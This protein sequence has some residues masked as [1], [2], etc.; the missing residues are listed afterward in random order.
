MRRLTPWEQK[1]LVLVS[2][3]LGFNQASLRVFPSRDPYTVAKEIGQAIGKA[4]L[5]GIIQKRRAV[6]AQ[7]EA[8]Q[9]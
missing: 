5:E 2:R 3:G 1:V 8:T 7:Q 9:S 4:S 6:N